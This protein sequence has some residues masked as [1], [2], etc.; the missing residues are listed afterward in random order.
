MVSIIIRI[1]GADLPKVF[2]YFKEAHPYFDQDVVIIVVRIR[3]SMLL[4][5]WKKLV[6]T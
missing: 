4:W 6:L 2:H 3:L 1:E 5:S